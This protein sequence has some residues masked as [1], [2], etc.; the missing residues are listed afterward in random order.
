MLTPL[1][2]CRYRPGRQGR[3][4]SPVLGNL[5]GP[6]QHRRMFVGCGS[7]RHCQRSSQNDT[8]G[9]GSL[10]VGNTLCG[11]PATLLITRLG[12]DRPQ[13]FVHRAASIGHIIKWL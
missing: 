10:P 13:D 6:L 11:T 8:N 3:L 2:N 1:Q 5:E 12:Q 4:D 7:E 9:L